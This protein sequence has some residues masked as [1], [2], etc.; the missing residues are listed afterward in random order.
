MKELI[1]YIAKSLASSP[2][3]VKVT[4]ISE[5][6]ALDAIYSLLRPGD[7]P[8]VETARLALSSVFFDPRRYDLG[9]VGRYK[10]N[11]RLGT[12]TPSHETVLTK[13]D[14]VEILRYLI[15]LSEGRGVTDDIDHLGNRRVKSLITSSCTRCASILSCVSPI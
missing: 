15:E 8:N 13:E 4:E 9:R 11:K 12:D 6:E 5:E 10:I 7:S 2:E 3:E 14:F 1:E